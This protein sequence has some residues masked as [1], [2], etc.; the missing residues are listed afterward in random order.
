MKFIVVD[1][2][3]GAGGVTSGIRKARYNGNIIADVVACINHDDTAIKSHKANHKK[4]IH[5]TEDIKVFD[6]KKL[7]VSR[8]LA[9]IEYIDPDYVMIENVREFMAWGSLDGNGK[10]V[11]MDKGKDYLKWVKKIQSY[12]YNYDYR[13][14]DAADFGAYC[15]RKR[16]FGLFAKIGLPLKF[17]QPT[18]SKKPNPMF[19]T[20]QWKPV[21]EC[22][23]LKDEGNSIFERK[24]EL[25]ENTLKRILEGLKKFA[26]YD[27]FIFTSVSSSLSKNGIKYNPGK[28]VDSVSPIDNQAV[29]NVEFL[30][31]YHGAGINIHSTKKPCSTISTKDRLSVIKPVH[32]LDCQYSTGRKNQSDNEPSGSILTNPKERLVSVKFLDMQYSDSKNTRDID[33]PSGAITKNPKVSLVSPKFI[34]DRQYNNKAGSLDKP[35]KTIIANQGKRPMYL[36]SPILSIDD[37]KLF[38]V[39]YENDTDTMKLIKEFMAENG[40]VDIKMRMLKVSELKKIMGLPENYILHGNQTKQK[41]MIGNMVHPLM[42]KKWFEALYKELLKNPIKK[43]A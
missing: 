4:T 16:Y 24:K 33:S 40:I 41:W 12:G 31:E 23:D 6:L 42:S 34:I 18:H 9:E 39:I 2:F 19:N 1:L 22:L 3:C 38:I 29:V 10:P 15:L 5:F 11:S 32:F 20:K 17:P 30:T 43:A 21:R 26:T 14:L 7:P 25:S 28:S 35:A 37:E 36:I 8:T 13:L 27:K